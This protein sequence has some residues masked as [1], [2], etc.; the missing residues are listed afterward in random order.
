MSTEIFVLIFH[1]QLLYSYSLTP[2]LTFRAF[3]FASN[4]THATAASA[5][6]TH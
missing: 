5:P 1:S 2:I 4:K 3:M 6:G